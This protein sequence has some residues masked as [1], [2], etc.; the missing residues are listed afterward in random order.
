MWSTVFHIFHI[1]HVFPPCDGLASHPGGSRNTPSRFMLQ[2]LEISA[3]LMCRL[4]LLYFMSSLPGP[5]HWGRQGACSGNA[6]LKTFV[7]FRE[8]HAVTP[9]RNISTRL[10][11]DLMTW[12]CFRSPCSH[13]SVLRAGDRFTCFFFLAH[14]CV[15][16]I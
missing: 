16:R 10:D 1:F 2:K 9:L 8:T 14:S 5:L 11:T 4:H 12:M 6:Q 13:P 15:K 3:G 7:P